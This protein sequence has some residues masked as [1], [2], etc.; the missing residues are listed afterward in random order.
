VV[1]SLATLPTGIAIM[2]KIEVTGASLTFTVQQNK[3]VSLKEYLLKGMFRR[4]HNPE[5]SIHALSDITLSARDGDRI[6]IIGPNGAGKTTFL[7][8][9]AGIYPPTQGT[10][11]VEG[12]ICSLFDIT[13]GFEQDATGWENIEYRSYL[14]GESPKSLKAK[15]D[16]IGAFSELGDFLNFP[17]RGYS[18]GMRMRLAFAIATATEPEILL[19]DE[20]LAVGDMAFQIKAR[21]RMRELMSASRLMV[22]VSHDLTTIYQT[23]NRA[24]WLKRGKVELAGEP[25]AVIDAYRAHVVHVAGVLAAREAEQAAAP[26]AAEA[27]TVADSTKAA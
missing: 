6:G 26:K 8:L 16:G 5:V 20:V 15:M 12:K 7:K 4:S 27:P 9:L 2:P 22:V 18:A 11:N 13:L 3:Q 17:V 19:V 25:E 14:Q 1:R 24:L 21:A 23:C 10:C